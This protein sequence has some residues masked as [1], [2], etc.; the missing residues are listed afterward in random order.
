MNCNTMSI[1]ARLRNAAALLSSLPATVAAA[2]FAHGHGALGLPALLGV[3]AASIAAGGLGAYLLLSLL[4]KPSA[5]TVSPRT[6]QVRASI[7]S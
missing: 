1:D 7:V 4:R 2:C 3:L 5:G 6:A